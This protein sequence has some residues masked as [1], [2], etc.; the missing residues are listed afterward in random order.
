[1][2]LL[3]C[4]ALYPLAFAQLCG[5]GSEGLATDHCTAGQ[6]LSQ[7]H[8]E[9]WWGLAAPPAPWALACS[10]KHQTAF[11]SCCKEDFSTGPVHGLC[12]L[13]PQ[14]QGRWMLPPTAFLALRPI[15]IPLFFH[16]ACADAANPRPCQPWLSLLGA[17]PWRQGG[18]GSSQPAWGG[19]WL[20][21]WCSLAL[22]GHWRVSLGWRVASGREELSS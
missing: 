21:C 1:M 4:F 6:M 15:S 7:K 14:C 12:T 8:N 2:F 13:P 22:T 18:S 16:C 20:C 19:W 9:P 17:S 10:V 5:Q 11:F 3:L